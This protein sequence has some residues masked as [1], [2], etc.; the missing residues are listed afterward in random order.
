MKD[1][2]L[3]EAI[4]DHK[5]SH[6]TSEPLMG[7]STQKVHIFERIQSSS[8]SPKL[9]NLSSL[10]TSPAF[11][12]ACLAFLVLGI[13]QFSHFKNFEQM[14]SSEL[15]IVE[16]SLSLYEENK[17]LYTNEENELVEFDDF[18]ILLDIV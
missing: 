13:F 8:E 16:E 12:M 5:R 6:P 3:K 7:A 17:D 1:E 15:T 4:Q 18:F 2:N 11:A 14:S 10:F 9:K